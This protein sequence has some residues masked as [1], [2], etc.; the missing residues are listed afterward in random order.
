MHS[1]ELAR[2]ASVTVR[3]LRHYHQIGLLPEPAR[4]GNGYRDYDVHDLIRVLRITRLAALGIPLERMPALL[5]APENDAPGVD[6]SGSDSLDSRGGGLLD[7]LDAELA[8]KIG[9]LTEQ[10][11]LIARIR[12]HRAPPDLP[13]E[14]APFL[15]VFV[16]AGL[17]PDLARIDRDHSVLLAHLVG[18]EG[19]PRL[20]RF[21]ERLSTSQ[22]APVAALISERFGR[23]GPESTDEEIS[24]LVCDLVDAYAPVLGEFSDDAVLTEGGGAAMLFEQYTADVF[25]EQQRRALAQLA[26][27]L[28]SATAED[29][30]PFSH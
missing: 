8:T 7:E 5:D 11:E 25:N 21:Y 28:D 3:A 12:D 17:P 16:A 19:M 22:V 14:L 24:S 13:P 18:E 6:G 9:R 26:A 30:H 29:P 23:L 4:G 27:A 10:R 20:A 1:A 2:L 15:A